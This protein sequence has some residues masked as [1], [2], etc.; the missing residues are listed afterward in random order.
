MIA[1]SRKFEVIV[2]DNSSSNYDPQLL[3]TDN[4]KAK[5][6]VSVKLIGIETDSD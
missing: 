1:N 2:V 4:K 6:Q 3:N 5:S